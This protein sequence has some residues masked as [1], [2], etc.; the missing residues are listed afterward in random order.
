M[1]KFLNI[2]KK[3]NENKNGKVI[4]FDFDNTI[5]KSFENGAEPEGNYQFGGLNYEIIK[6]MKKFKEG[7]ATVLVVTS[8]HQVKEDPQT[9]IRTMLDSLGLEVDG[10]FYTNGQPKAQK[11]YELGS[12]LH[13]DDD[14]AEH[15]AIKAY[16]NLHK[17]DIT[18]KF[19]DDL[20]SDTNE[21]AKGVI[22]TADGLFIIAQ[23][24]DSYEWDAVGG[25]LMKG[26]EAPFAFWREIKEEMGLSVHSVEYL[27]SMDTKWKKKKKLVHYFM[28]RVS[29]TKE[30]LKGAI[31]LQW[32]LSDYFCGNFSAIEEKLNSPEG[33]TQN[34]QNTINFLLKEN[35]LFEIEDFQKKMIKP[36]QKG[37]ERLLRTGPQDEIPAT[38]MENV[39][40]MKRSKSAPPGFGAIGEEKEAKRKKK[41]KI[42]F[43][44]ELDEKKSKKKR[45]KGK[46]RANKYHWGV[47][48]WDYGGGYGEGGSDGGGE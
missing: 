32:E 41:L 23:R 1:K 15:E 37:K 11:I 13:Y 12:S 29:Y 42:R 6:R 31:E 16:G 30:E 19:P 48:G 45:K 43:K 18:V 3:L 34:L 4:T 47:P 33:A 24:S 28:G 38:G 9:S 17:N 8:R 35:L 36:H 2:M 22:L 26:E 21:V 27:G 10:I 39:I 7:G 5:V 40:D 20:I 25:H 44:S 14:P 46:K